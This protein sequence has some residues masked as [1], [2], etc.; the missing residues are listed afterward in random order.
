M[1]NEDFEMN[2]KKRYFNITGQRGCK[3]GHIFD[4]NRIPCTNVPKYYQILIKI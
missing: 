1:Y 4:E 2:I 3:V